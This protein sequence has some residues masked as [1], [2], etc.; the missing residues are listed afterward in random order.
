[1]DVGQLSVTPLIDG[2][3]VAPPAYF[4]PD[5]SFAGHERLLDADGNMRL[6][7][8]C[9]LLRGGPLGDRAILLDAGSGVIDIPTLRGG[10]LVDELMRAGCRPDDVDTVVCSHLHLDHCGGLI[11]H[12]TSEVFPRASLVVGAA[13][14]ARFVDEEADFMLDHTR[15]GVREL[16]AAGRVQLVDADTA[17]APG[18]STMTAPGHT[19]GHFVVVISD[20]TERA[21]LLGDAITCPLQLT[22][23]DWGAISDVDP[24]LARRTRQ[25]IWDEL[26][27]SDA[28]AVGAHF[29]GLS[30]GRMMRANGKRWWS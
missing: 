5:T 13:D 4:G 11:R 14:W 9:F 1:M 29:P 24:V 3:F 30:F 23:T 25:R 27:G 16:M 19:P 20:G 22:E 15:H 2:E 26:E 28:A 10:G 12:D 17:L 6:P 7:V 21:L 18:V 8:G